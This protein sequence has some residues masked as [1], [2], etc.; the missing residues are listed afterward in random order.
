MKKKLLA[1]LLTGA[2][3]ASLLAGCGSN[4]GSKNE[5]SKEA[6]GKES[7]QEALLP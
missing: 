6:A 5:D 3:A 4:S 7:G 2:M 1:V